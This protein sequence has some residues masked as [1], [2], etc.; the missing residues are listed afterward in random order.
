MVSQQEQAI[1]GNSTG[2]IT[3]ATTVGRVSYYDAVNYA[4][5]R[6]YVS[7][8]AFTNSGSACTVNKTF[9]ANSWIKSQINGT[10]A[11]IVTID[12]F[13]IDNHTPVVN[14]IIPS[15]TTVTCIINLRQALL[16]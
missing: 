2:A 9:T 13:T 7:N 8:V 5:T 6:L 10:E 11:R 12:N 16:L 3:S 4:N 1:Q 14:M 15:M